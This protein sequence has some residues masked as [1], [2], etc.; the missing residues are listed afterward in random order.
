M[1]EKQ[2]LP[3]CS[4]FC[5]ISLDGFLAKPDGDIDW[6]TGSAGEGEEDA[7]QQDHGFEAFMAGVDTLV[8]GRKTFEK[9]MTFDKWYYGGKRVVVLSHSPLDLGPAKARGG[10]VEQ[11]SGSPAE[12]AAKLGAGGAKSLYID[13]GLTIQ[14]FLR[15]GLI[16]RIIVSQ[17]PVLIGQ[18][19]PLFGPLD[20]D[21]RL[22]LVSSRTFPGGMV[23]SEYKVAAE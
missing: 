13:G 6:L 9:V 21:I 2:S 17:L 1:S 20:R 7:S 8:M 18:G 15:A 3:T 14:G 22:R 11:M 12:V 19:I 5:G 4:V 16:G 23:Q 10:V